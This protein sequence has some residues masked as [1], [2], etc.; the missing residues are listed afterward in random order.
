MV[1][2]KCTGNHEHHI[3]TLAEKKEFEAIKRLTTKPQYI[4]VNCGRVADNDVNLCKPAD[5]D[6]I[7][8]T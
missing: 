3:C 5:I 6:L 8:L 4:C 2:Q 7:T 1:E